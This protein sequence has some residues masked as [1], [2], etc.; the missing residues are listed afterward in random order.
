MD[1]KCF[2]ISKYANTSMIID[3]I[4][5]VCQLLRDD[6]SRIAMS[7]G[8]AMSHDAWEDAVRVTK[9]SIIEKCD[10]SGSKRFRHLDSNR[11]IRWLVARLANNVS[12]FFQF[13]Y[14]QSN[15]ESPNITDD[16]ESEDVIQATENLVEIENLIRKNPDVVRN[17]MVDLYEF[18]LTDEHFDLYDFHE[19]CLRIGFNPEEFE[20]I[21]IQSKLESNECGHAQLIF[22]LEDDYDLA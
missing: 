15:T 9:K 8:L 14:R 4:D 13:Y 17:A 11:A 12:N 19:L 3:D 22:A 10:L 7:R 20:K 18:A 5:N 1:L 16:Y 2:L 6:V 21:P